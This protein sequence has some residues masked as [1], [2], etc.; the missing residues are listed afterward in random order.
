MP[1]K[2]PKITESEARIQEASNA[3]D[4]NPRLK[5]SVAARRFGV[6]Y[7]TL[8]RRRE[9]VPPS[10]TRGGHNKKLN[11]V[12]D[13]ALQD[14]V[15]MLYSCGTS[16]TLETVHAAANRLLYYSTGNLDTKVSIRWTKAWIKR[17]SNLQT[18]TSNRY[19]QND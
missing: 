18:L 5:A 4:A 7:R 12:Q 2:S 3:M 19:L 16:A 17:Q 14:Y 1:P 13:K 6:A 10:N 15:F 9:G 8:L 11:S